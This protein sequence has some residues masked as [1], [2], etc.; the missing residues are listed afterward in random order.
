MSSSS[1]IPAPLPDTSSGLRQRDMPAA[2][3][4]APVTFVRNNPNTVQALTNAMVR[5]LLWL[6][7]ATPDRWPRPCR[8]NICL[9]TRRC[10]WRASQGEGRV[11]PRWPAR[12]PGQARIR[13]ATWPR[14]IRRSSPPSHQPGADIRSEPRREGV[15]EIPEIGAPA[16][17][18]RAEGPAEPMAQADFGVT[19]PALLLEHITCTFASRERPGERYTAVKDTTLSVRRRRVRFRRRPDRLRQIDA[20]QRRAPACSS[21]RRA[22]CTCS[23]SRLPASIAAPATC[24]RPNR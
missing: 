23:A 18:E 11:L 9:A 10:I 6:Q 13:C 16:C 1:P 14:S 20:A 3:L 21:R 8:R 2:A 5:A 4:Y 24:S 22:A 15:G 17:P 19:R 7:K 12:R